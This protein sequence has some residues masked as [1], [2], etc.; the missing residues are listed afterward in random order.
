MFISMVNPSTCTR[1][2]VRLEW[3]GVQRAGNAQG[4]G[5]AVACQGEGERGVGIE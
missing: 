1:C 4:L 5:G 3:V 2:V